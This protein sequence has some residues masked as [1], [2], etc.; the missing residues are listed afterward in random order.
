MNILEWVEGPTDTSIEDVYYLVVV[1]AYFKQISK[2]CK[3]RI[4][5]KS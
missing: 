3:V 5:F 1:S 2:D 4:P